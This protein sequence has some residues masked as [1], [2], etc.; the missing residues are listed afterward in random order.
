MSRR[1]LLLLTA[2]VAVLA[3]PPAA[4]AAT[5]TGSPNNL[6]VNEDMEVSTLSGTGPEPHTV[7]ATVTAL[8]P[9]GLHVSR[10]HLDLEIQERTATSWVS[11]V[12]TLHALT[13][14]RL[15]GTR[16]HRVWTLRENADQIDG[17]LANHVQMR[18]YA[19]FSGVCRGESL[20]PPLLFGLTEPT[21][22]PT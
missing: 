14:T 18:V 5:A 8:G 9:A 21:L 15:P 17:L 3:G 4:L 7:M 22:G 6:C 10:L 19:K 13:Y 1:L 2:T 12:T 16:L 11:F 20:G